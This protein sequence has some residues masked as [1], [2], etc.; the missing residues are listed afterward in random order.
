LFYLASEWLL[1]R[2]TDLFLFESAYGRAVFEAKLGSPPSLARVVHNG[3]TAK[4]FAPISTDAQASDLVFVGELRAL[5][6]VDVLIEAIAMLNRA[7]KSTTATIVGEGPDRRKFEALAKAHGLSKS[8]RF[9]GAKPARIA[10]ALGRL[11][12]V[13]SR[14]E[15]LPYV[16]LEGAAGAVPMIATR[17]GGIA[18]I[19]NADASALVPA[20]DPG[21]LAHSIEHALSHPAAAAAAAQRLQ[22]RVRAAFSVDVMAQAVLAAYGEALVRRQAPRQG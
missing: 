3:V 12:V 17:V 18:E 19:F 8:V 16:V 9:V 6:G 14:A 5:K 21:A 11:L 1:M 22:A 7:G 2:R 4:E 15:S 13:P 10:F 20:G